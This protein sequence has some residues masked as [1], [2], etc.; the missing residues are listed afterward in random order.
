MRG[1]SSSTP[2]LSNPQRRP[3]LRRRAG[4]H[5]RRETLLVLARRSSRPGVALW[6]PDPRSIQ[7][8]QSRP[9]VSAQ[10]S[11]LFDVECHA[12]AKNI[13]AMTGNSILRR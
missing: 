9:F 4:V 6:M 1:R 12:Q 3:A 13:A 5:R 8:K 2:T 7:Q 11:C 10:A